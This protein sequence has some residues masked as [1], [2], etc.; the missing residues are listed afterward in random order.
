MNNEKEESER[1]SEDLQIQLDELDLCI[2]QL[3]KD[4]E[5]QN[6]LSKKKKLYFYQKK[7]LLK[8]EKLLFFMFKI[9]KEVYVVGKI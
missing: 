6:S 2:A 3:Q 1:K 5:C 4:A 9:K 7:M 8:V